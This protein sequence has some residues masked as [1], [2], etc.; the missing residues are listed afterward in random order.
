MN[1]IP[2]SMKAR[3]SAFA[4]RFFSLNRTAPH[5][6]EIIT[7]LLLTRETTEIIESGWLSAVKYAKSAAE[8]N[9]EV[10]SH[11]MGEIDSAY[12]QEAM[13]YRRERKGK[14]RVKWGVLFALYAEEK[15]ISKHR[16]CTLALDLDRDPENADA[17]LVGDA[18]SDKE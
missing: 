2:M 3:S 16:K 14:T 9:M 4:L 17:A 1:T 18:L 12:I 10:F 15:K 7:E 11:A 13:V 5:M 6:N 8:M